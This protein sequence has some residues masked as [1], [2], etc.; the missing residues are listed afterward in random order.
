MT[1]GNDL[2]SYKLLLRTVELVQG[3]CSTL[4]DMWVT[5]GTLGQVAFGKSIWKILWCTSS[6]YFPTKC[7]IITEEMRIVWCWCQL[8]HCFGAPW[9]CCPGWPST[10]NLDLGCGH[11]RVGKAC[12]P[13]DREQPFPGVSLG[14]LISLMSSNTSQHYS[15]KRNNH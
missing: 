2:I 1:I 8:L 4:E 11:S 7:L 9:Q 6:E 5:P 13:G 15:E 3:F 14:Q 12:C 10:L